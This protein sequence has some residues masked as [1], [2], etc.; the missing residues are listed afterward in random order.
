MSFVITAP[1]FGAK[2]LDCIDVCPTDSIH[3]AEEMVY[4]DP[5]TCIDCGMCEYAC[6]VKA[7]M[8]VEDVPVMW[9]EFIDINAELAGRR[10]L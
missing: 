3:K 1:C 8:S 4:I 10:G 2:Y 9:K 5:D 7:P 6:P